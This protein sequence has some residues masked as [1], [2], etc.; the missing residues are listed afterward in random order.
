MACREDGINVRMTR[1]AYLVSSARKVIKSLRS[2]GFLRPPKAILVPGMYFLGFSRY[3]NC[4]VLADESARCVFVWRN[5]R[6]CRC[7][8]R[9]PSACWRR[10]MRSPRPDRSYGRRD[11]VGWG[12][13]CCPH[14]PSGCG[15]ERN[16]S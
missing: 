7:S 5:V 1:D 4:H 9:C 8:T 11:R 10:C 3:S 2:L 6:E 15:T 13:S 12:R 16:G 14:P